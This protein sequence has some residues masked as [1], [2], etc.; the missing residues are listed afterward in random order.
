M[1]KINTLKVGIIGGGFGYYG[2]YKA[3]QEIDSCK[4][5]AIATRKKISISKNVKIY[6][7]PKKLIT[8]ENLDIISVATIPKNQQNL[9]LKLIKTSSNL[10]LEKPLGINYLVCKNRLSKI[11][12]SKIAINFTFP[13]IDEFKY[14]KNKFVKKKDK[15]I[16]INWV[17][18]NSANK[19]NTWKNDKKMGGGIIFNYFSHS[20]YYIEFLFGQ[21]IK[22]NNIKKS[23]TIFNCEIFTKNEKKIIFRL[24][25][26]SKIKKR[27]EIIINKKNPIKLFSNDPLRFNKFKIYIK[28]KIVPIRDYKKIHDSDSRY[29]YVAKLL[30]R[31]IK[32]IN[33]NTSFRPDHLD[34]LKNLMWLNKIEKI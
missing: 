10:F 34:G 24:N 25:C 16:S 5:I 32:A 7:D 20:L 31:Y 9:L 13:E 17:F 15:N 19:L 11:K 12:D 3:F 18:D 28:N 22:I 26:N 8:S 14:F 6:S 2:H 23:K 21:I 30:K 27:H 29:F 33:T 1:T 4:V